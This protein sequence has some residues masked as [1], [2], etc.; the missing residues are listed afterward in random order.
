MWCRL[1]NNLYVFS[2]WLETFIN[3]SSSHF[4]TRARALWNC[5]DNKLL[6]FILYFQ[7]QFKMDHIIFDCLE[8]IANHGFGLKPTHFVIMFREQ[9]R[10]TERS[11]RNFHWWSREKK[12]QQQNNATNEVKVLKQDE[13]LIFQWVFGNFY[14]SCNN[15]TWTHGKWSSASKLWQSYACEFHMQ[16]FY[17][18]FE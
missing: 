5:P 7:S 3:F 13:K 17:F 6:L 4:H 14:F 12:Q 2:L 16:I 1:Y 10:N 18:N 15:P 11:M 8:T 9:T